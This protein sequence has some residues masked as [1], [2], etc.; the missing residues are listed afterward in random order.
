MN[1][2]KENCRHMSRLLT[3][4]ELAVFALLCHFTSLTVTM[5]Q[6]PSADV[7]ISSAVSSNPAVTASNFDFVVSISNRGPSAA[8]NVILT[9]PMPDNTSFRAL[10][11]PPG[12]ACAPPPVG[13]TTTIICVNQSLQ[14]GGPSLVVL[15]LT[16]GCALADG[17][18][19]LNNASIGSSSSDP[20]PF[21]DPDPSNNQSTASVAISNPTRLTPTSRTF[22]S[23][24]GTTAWS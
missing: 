18:V 22:T 14:V 2:N 3:W 16:V 9:I 10:S 23:S 20:N 1:Q 15:T 7:L 11:A 24:G 13:V 17:I 5:A 4:V 6:A 21:I 8:P 19:L 12:W